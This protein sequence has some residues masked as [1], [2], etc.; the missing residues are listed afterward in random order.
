MEEPLVSAFPG[1]LLGVGL[2][3]EVS[4]TLLPPQV[5]EKDLPCYL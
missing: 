1:S 4:L 5:I 3:K 2:P